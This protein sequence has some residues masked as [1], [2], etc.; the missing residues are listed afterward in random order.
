M[1]RPFLADPEFVNKAEEERADEINTCIGCN[2]ACLDHLFEGKEASCLVNPW[3]CRE[4]EHIK[5]LAICDADK[6]LN[7]AVVGAGPAGLSFATEAASRGHKVTLFDSADKI[8]GQFNIAKQIPGKEEFYETLRYFKRQLELTGVELNLGQRVSSEQLNQGGFDHVVLATG[9]VPRA[10]NI[11]GSDH[12]KVLSYLDVLRDKKPV[13]KKVAIIGAGGIGFDVAEYLLHDNKPEGNGE[14]TPEQRS[15][16]EFTASW[17]IDKELEHPGS[18][19]GKGKPQ[20][21]ADRELFLLQRKAGKVGADLGKTTGWIH[22]TELH[23]HGVKMMNGCEYL[24]INDGG[25]QL[26]NGEVESLL[27]VDTIVICA[28]QEPLQ[29][30]TND[31]SV[32]HTLIGGADIAAGLDAKRAIAQGAEL[33]ASL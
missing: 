26:R 19:T 22:R 2:Q 4:T 6:A 32:P 13:G 10:L 25:L 17:G 24:S 8:G 29:E 7:V 27:E 33:A 21:P 9:V 28:G 5:T 11:T 12:P 31:L 3:A 23:R 15:I 20:H 16:D 18:L 14:E 30:L 1:A